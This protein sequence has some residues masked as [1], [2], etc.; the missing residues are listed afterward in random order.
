LLRDFALWLCRI[1]V[2]LADVTQAN[3]HASLPTQTEADWLWRLLN[4]EADSQPLLERAQLIANLHEAEKHG[5]TAWIHATAV[6]SQHFGA[7]PPAALPVRPPNDWSAKHKSWIALK[8]LTLAFYEKGLKDGLPYRADGLVTDIQ[9]ERITYAKFVAEFRSAH[10]LDVQPDAREVCVLCGGRLGEPEVDHW[11]NKAGFPLLS[12]CA[13]NLLPACCDCNSGNDAKGQKP[14][15]D[16][17]SFTNWF[18][19]YLRPGHGTFRLNYVLPERAIRCVAIQAVDQPKV[20]NLDQLLNLTN[21]WTR[22]FKAEYRKKQKELSDRRRRGRGPN[23]LATLQ[24]WVTDF[25]DGLIATEPHHEV[26]KALAAAL[27]EPRHLA[28]WNSDIQEL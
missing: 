6:I 7:H 10:K 4:R 28:S 26:H 27:L 1:D 19:P 2:Y 14:V 15:H 18:H 21:R 3:L 23:D 8:T 22:E 16:A 5:L 20:N 12:V 24:Q 25:H 11:V 17:G 9:A 13:D